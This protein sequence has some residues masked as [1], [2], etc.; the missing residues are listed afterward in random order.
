VRAIS[1]RGDDRKAFLLG[2]GEEPAIQADERERGGSRL[3]RHERRG[4]LERLT[5]AERVTAD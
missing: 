1:Q 5:S 2:C 3:A 4:K